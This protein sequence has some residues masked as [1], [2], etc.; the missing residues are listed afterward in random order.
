[1]NIG[2]AMK[3]AKVVDYAL[4]QQLQPMMCELKPRPSIYYPDFIAANQSERCDNVMLGSKADNLKQIR[5]D[6]R[7][8][9]QKEKLDKV[10]D[11]L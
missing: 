5:E 8:F 11:T 1:M 2:D 3:R 6:I 10:T 7:D 9:K 4:Q